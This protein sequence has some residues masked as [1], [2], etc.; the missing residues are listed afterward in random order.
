M[1]TITTLIKH[2][3][4]F[5]RRAIVL[6]SHIILSHVFLQMLFIIDFFIQMFWFEHH[7][8]FWCRLHTSLNNF[9]LKRLNT[10]VFDRLRWLPSS[11]HVLFL[12]RKPSTRTPKPKRNN[13]LVFVDEKERQKI[14]KKHLTSQIRNNLTTHRQKKTKK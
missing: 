4:R 11:V 2:K 1:T 5:S 7:W 12:T 9:Q 6:L 13:Y 3:M 10:V 8:Q 14:L